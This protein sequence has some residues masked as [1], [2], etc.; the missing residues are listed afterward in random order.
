MKQK[1]IYQNI[2]KFILLLLLMIYCRFS[3]AEGIKNILSDQFI[4]KPLHLG[5]T[6]YFYSN[7]GF[8]LLGEAVLQ[9]TP[10]LQ[11]NDD[12]EEE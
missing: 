1:Y 3:I 8:G 5:C 2:F 10:S 12:N 6:H 11:T 9:N 4:Q 7:I